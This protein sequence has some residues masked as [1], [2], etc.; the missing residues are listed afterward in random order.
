M[1]YYDYHNHKWAKNLAHGRQLVEKGDFETFYRGEDLPDND[2]YPGMRVMSAYW[3]SVEHEMIMRKG[4][5]LK[6]AGKEEWSEDA[7]LLAQMEDFSTRFLDD[8]RELVVERDIVPVERLEPLA[9]EGRE[10]PTDWVETLQGWQQA[11][12]EALESDDPIPAELVESWFDSCLRSVY[13]YNY[14]LIWGG[15]NAAKLVKDGGKEA[16]QAAIDAVAEEFKWEISKEF[17]V[18]VMPAVGFEDVGDLMELGMRGMFSDQYY[19]SGEERE[20]GEKTVKE[21]LLMNCELAG[22]Y[23]RCAEWNGL[24]KTDLGYGV[25]RFCE[26]HGEATMEVTIPPSFSPAYQLKESLGM[27]DKMCVFK[28]ELT[29]A[30]DMDRLMRVQA[31]IFGMED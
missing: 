27:D 31:K 3:I 20:V 9:G 1:H 17:Y 29:P 26:A 12:E 19:K 22:I 6:G 14:Y 15:I 21:S 11:S 2:V 18:N 16:L 4:M 8:M 7:N 13:N 24:E 23:W 28:L 10:L 25:C 30:D 5:L